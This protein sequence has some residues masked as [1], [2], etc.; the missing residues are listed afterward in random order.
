MDTSDAGPRNGM[1]LGGKRKN[2]NNG[3]RCPASKPEKASEE[4]SSVRPCGR[5]KKYNARDPYRGQVVPLAV[6]DKVIQRQLT[7]A[8]NFT[9]AEPTRFVACGCCAGCKMEASCGSCLLCLLHYDAPPGARLVCMHRVYSAPTSN[10]SWGQ[11]KALWQPKLRLRK[12]VVFPQAIKGSL[13]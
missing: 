9:T 1:L 11:N 5:P 4:G 13:C 6:S 8:G 7:S 2:T 12:V 10:P 3:S